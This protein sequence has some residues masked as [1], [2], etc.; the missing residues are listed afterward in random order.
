MFSDVDLTDKTTI[1]LF[2]LDGSPLGTYSAP[3]R[4]D[5]GGLSFLGVTYSDALIARVRI[6]L[7]TGALAATVSDVTAGGS[8][9]LVV[10]D[11][12]IY[13]EPQAAF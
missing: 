7:G 8:A 9:D 6:T 11:N 1:Q 2:A 3:V 12:L 10:L 13:G 5:G 4:S